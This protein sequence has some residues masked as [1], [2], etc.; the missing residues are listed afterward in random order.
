MENVVARIH[1][2]FSFDL[3][4]A[5]RDANHT[6][7]LQRIKPLLVTD[8]V[9]A[10]RVEYYR[11]KYPNQNF[12]TEK[13]IEEICIKYGLAMGSLMMFSASIPTKNRL[14]ISRF[15]LLPA[16]V[17]FTDNDLPNRIL[18]RAMKSSAAGSVSTSATGGGGFVE[19]RTGY[20]PSNPDKPFEVVPIGECFTLL[21]QPDDR[22]Y[23]V[24]LEMD[25]HGSPWFIEFGT[26][27]IDYGDITF[28]WRQSHGGFIPMP[29]PPVSPHRPTGRERPPQ[30]QTARIINHFSEV[31]LRLGINHLQRA[32]RLSLSHNVAPMV[33]AD[34]SMFQRYGDAVERVGHR[35]KFKRSQIAFNTTLS[36]VDDPIILQPVPFG[37][38]V[39]TKW[40]AESNIPEF[41][42]TRQS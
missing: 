15:Q 34:K 41:A 36:F 3:L 19:F 6:V 11:I 9:F 4:E 28:T 23:R 30:I 27:S 39:V 22:T 16:D 14:E 7:F 33:V 10:D 42:D 18:R 35:M 1:R 20:V 12:V 26:G 40:G 2:D 17:T 29:P 24:F 21:R 5:V 32:N 8:R 31:T 25:I 37:Y 38:L 13:Q